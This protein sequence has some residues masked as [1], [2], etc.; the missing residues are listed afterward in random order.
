[1]GFFQVEMTAGL[2][3]SGVTQQSGG[4]CGWWEE[5]ESG[6]NAEGLVPQSLVPEQ[7][8]EPG[9]R[10][11]W[12]GMWS[13]SLS[14]PRNDAMSSCTPLNTERGPVDGLGGGRTLNVQPLS[15]ACNLERA[16]LALLPLGFPHL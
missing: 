15:C 2:C 4:P 6:A 14:H 16:T 5:L 9:L 11:W 1:M 10:P 12:V 13:G 8:P 7:G 3:A